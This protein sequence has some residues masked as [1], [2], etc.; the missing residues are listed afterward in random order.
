MEP[1]LSRGDLLF[2]FLQ[3]HEQACELIR[4]HPRGMAAIVAETTG[5]VDRDFILEAYRISPNY[6]ASLP[7]EY[8]AS[9][10]KFV[11]TL[12]T[13]GYISRFVSREE[14]FDTTLVEKVHP[15][16]H[17]YRAGISME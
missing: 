9:T 13:L 17:H 14:I 3:A 4:H 6:C 11:D 2:G 5:M 12:G 8:V 10:V 1:L 16:P 7:P 15:G